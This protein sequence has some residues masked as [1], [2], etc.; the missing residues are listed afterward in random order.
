LRRPAC[1]DAQT[2]TISVPPTAPWQSAEAVNGTA[3][4]LRRKG[5]ELETGP[6]DFKQLRV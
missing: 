4:P 3:R 1:A 6:G 5:E 2:G